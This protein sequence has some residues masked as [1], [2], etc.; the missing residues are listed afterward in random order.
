MRH[1]KSW[2][3]VV[4]LT[5]LATLL[6]AHGKASA[7][8]NDAYGFGLL[9]G[10]RNNGVAIYSLGEYDEN[11][12]IIRTMQH[13]ESR[14]DG[15]LRVQSI[16]LGNGQLSK[17]V[18]RF[19]LKSAMTSLD[20]Y[21]TRV[22]QILSVS[23]FG[24]LAKMSDSS[25]LKTEFDTAKRLVIVDDNFSRMSFVF[26][27]TSGAMRQIVV[28]MRDGFTTSLRFADNS[29]MAEEIYHKRLTKANSEDKRFVFRYNSDGLL[30]SATFQLGDGSRAL[31]RLSY[32]KL[33]LSK[34]ANFENDIALNESLYNYDEAGRLRDFSARNA[35]Q[36]RLR[37]WIR[38]DGA[39]RITNKLFWEGNTLQKHVVTNYNFA[40]RTQTQTT[41]D[42]DGK[43]LK[44]VKQLL[45]VT[46]NQP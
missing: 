29:R 43:V 30:Q 14:L 46:E 40:A 17:V 3:I 23:R 10:V 34:V 19:N 42:A 13:T 44:T 45:D 6:G 2:K 4:A 26:A 7:L 9:A 39:G 36:P 24:L 28:K 32:R 11:L 18:M 38:R 37:R 22:K 21:N 1:L 25:N 8:Q 35:G 5:L 15:T 16:F 20:F 41:F 12:K 33:K 27:P 31:S